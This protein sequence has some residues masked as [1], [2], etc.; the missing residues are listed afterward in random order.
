MSTF[1]DEFANRG[2]LYQ[3]TNLEGLKNLMSKKKI[4]AYIGFDC[5]ANSLHIGNLLQ[6]MILRLLQQHGHKPIILIGDATTTIGDPT[7]RDKLRKVLSTEEVSSN[8]KGIRK[9]LSKFIKFGD[10]ASDALMLSNSTWLNAIGY[11]EFLQK[12]GKLI[13]VN[14]MLSMDS[15]KSRLERMQQLTFLEFNYA[16]LQ[17]YD[18]CY[19]NRNYNC[20]LEIGGSDQWGNIVTGVELAR[21][22]YNIEVFGLTTPLITTASGEKMGKS[23]GGAAWI[24]EDMLTPYDYYQYWRNIQDEDV[25]RY[26]NL[27]A[28]FNKEQMQEFKLLVNGDINHAKKSLAHRLTAL[29]HGKDV[30]DHALT[31]SNKVFEDKCIDGNLPTLGVEYEVLQNGIPVYE[32]LY[33]ARLVSSKSEGR[34]LI[35]G[36]GARVNNE[37]VLDENMLISKSF[38]QD[39]YIKLSSGK[40]KHALVKVLDVVP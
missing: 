33:L 38:L 8:I 24:N 39:G 27:Y 31:A 23:V 25:L 9:S 5:T 2:Y 22:L 1:L 21:K 20:V 28:E 30:A 7:G 26:S 14:K 29:C 4:V 34:K 35:R 10:G 18:F 16:L 17:A 15:I 36:N 11:L 19:L 40:K 37:K 6:I 3:S 12:C 32:L 13:S